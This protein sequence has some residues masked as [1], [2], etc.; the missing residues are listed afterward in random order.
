[1]RQSVFV[2]FCFMASQAIASVV[3]VGGNS[4]FAAPPFAWDDPC[5]GELTGSNRVVM[6]RAINQLGLAAGFAP[7]LAPS[8]TVLKT[9]LD[10][11]RSGDIDVIKAIN[12]KVPTDQLVFGEVPTVIVRKAIVIPR[13]S[14][15]DAA[16]LASLKNLTGVYADN[17][18]AM[19]ERFSA[20]SI[21]LYPVD[22]TEDSY[23]DLLAGKAD[24]IVAPYYSSVIYLAKNSLEKQLKVVPVDEL[25]E[26]LYLATLRGSKNEAF[27][28]LLDEK[29]G[30]MRESG[31]IDRLNRQYL[32][33]WL[34]SKPCN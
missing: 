13:D 1:M 24:F 17:F 15:I 27:L 2:C 33:V 23:R 14:Q 11:L 7:S 20:L 32:Q 21:A 34:D 4:T 9:L 18:D 31:F 29:I 10:Q 28:P 22:L 8:P 19:Q 12:K 5:T 6:T 30:E 25:N 3:T 16:N 26:Y